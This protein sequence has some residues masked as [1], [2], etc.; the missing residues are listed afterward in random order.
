VHLREETTLRR[1]AALYES[2]YGQEWHFDVRDGAFAHSAGTALVFEVAP[3]TVFGF[4]KG[5][6]FS[7]TRWRFPDS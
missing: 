6:E 2:K 4:R 7:Q 1:V 3:R 5:D